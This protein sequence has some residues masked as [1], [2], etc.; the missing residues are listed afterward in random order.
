MKTRVHISLPVQDLAASTR[1]YE[2]LL[3]IAPTKV[4]ADYANFRLDSPGL[5]LALV[6]S[7]TAGKNP[8]GASHF[9]V[10]LFETEDL[11]AWRTRIQNAEIPHSIEEGVTCCYAVADKV[12]ATDPEGNRWEF[13]VRE[14]EAE[15][16][17][18]EPSECCETSCCS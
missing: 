12:W 14:A 8:V 7:P 18:E 10:E 4:K 1:F 13:W 17:A 16:M 5:H 11:A 3:G 6:S 2:T 9:G 15:T